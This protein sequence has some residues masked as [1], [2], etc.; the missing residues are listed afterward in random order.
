M[1]K[2]QLLDCLKERVA[3]DLRLPTY[4]TAEEIFHILEN[5][6]GNQAAIAIEIMEELQ[7]ILPVRDNQPQKIVELINAVEKT[8]YNLQELGNVDAL[9]EEPS[10]GEVH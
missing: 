8:L 6:Y 9:E 1:R 10:T 5:R 7:A 4:R 2:F 3:K